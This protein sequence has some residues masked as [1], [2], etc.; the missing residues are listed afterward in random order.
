MPRSGGARTHGLML[1]LLAL[2]CVLRFVSHYYGSGD[3]DDI[4]RPPLIGA[5]DQIELF[6]I[7]WSIAHGEGFSQGDH[8][9]LTELLREYDARP[10]AI[11]YDEQ[12]LKMLNDRGLLDDEYPA[13]PRRT[14]YRDLLYPYVAAPFTFAG[15]PF[16]ALRLLNVFLLCCN[17]WMIYF[18][19]RRLAL[20]SALTMLAPLLFIMHPRTPIAT[21]QLMTETLA[22]T[23]LGGFVFAAL[24]MQHRPGFR[25]AALLGVSIGLAILVKKQFLLLLPIVGVLFLVAL[26]QK[27]VAFQ[28]AAAVGVVAL[29]VASPLFINSWLV[30]KDAGLLTG[31]NGWNDMPAAYSQDLVELGMGNFYKIRTQTFRWYEAKF[32]TVVRGEIAGARAGKHLFFYMA[33]RPGFYERI[34]K[35]LW[36]KLGTEL[37]PGGS[38]YQLLLMLLGIAG[39]VSTIRNLESQ[40]LL[41]AIAAAI[42][43]VALTHGA[44]GRMVYCTVLIQCIGFAFAARYALRKLSTRVAL[45]RFLVE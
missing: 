45:P 42:G 22:T 14:A 40:L 27:R 24:A 12:Q 37:Y 38:A 33:E 44:Y 9:G 43:A 34:P 15:E 2:A 23:V 20:P 26:V 31:T 35:L 41:A 4:T 7:A 16:R 17:A 32:D 10:D 39:L 18:A 19:L 21:S 29:V 13:E 8:P 36:I 5:G 11:R 3:Y 30:T 25:T 6:R 28:H 1:A